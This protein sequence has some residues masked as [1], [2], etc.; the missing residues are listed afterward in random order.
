[1]KYEIKKLEEREVEET[2][3]LFKAIVDELHA[4]SSDIE[5]SHYK[6]THP[7]KKVREELKNKKNKL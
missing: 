5:R 1:M 7:V 6:A 2:V 4:D 3:E